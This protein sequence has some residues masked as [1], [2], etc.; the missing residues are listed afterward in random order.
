MRRLALLA[1]LIAA[2]VVTTGCFR[3]T[4]RNCSLFRGD[5]CGGDGGNRRGGLCDWDWFGTRDRY[6]PV[7]T[8]YGSCDTCV[9]C[10][11][12]VGC[13]V[14][15]YTAYSPGMEVMDGGVYYEGMDGGFDGSFRD[16]EVLGG[17]LIPGGY[18]GEIF[19]GS[20]GGILPGPAN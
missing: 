14:G 1:A 5:E 10:A 9:G 18:E 13:E 12:C 4:M 20:R 3:D 11:G 6:Q 19:E 8:G 16:G 17:S 15:G 7:V 2:C